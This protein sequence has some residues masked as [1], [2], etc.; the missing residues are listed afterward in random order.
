MSQKHLVALARPKQAG[1][2]KEVD[3]IQGVI[4]GKKIDASAVKFDAAAVISLV[5]NYGEKVDVT[6]EFGGVTMNGFVKEIQRHAMTK[7][8]SHIDI[9]INA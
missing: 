2:F 6:V 8:I 1:N 5:H 4:Y 7:A 9:Q 3:F